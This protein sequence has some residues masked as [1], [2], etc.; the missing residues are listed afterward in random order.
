MFQHFN[1]GNHSREVSKTKFKSK[2][3]INGCKLE[4]N[5]INRIDHLDFFYFNLLQPYLQRFILN[6]LIVN[7]RFISLYSYN[8]LLFSIVLGH[9][10]AI[11]SRMYL[12]YFEKRIYH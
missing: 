5:N 1:P 2:L 6:N 3:S 8:S 10:R 9:L 4:L 7:E 11:I 12:D